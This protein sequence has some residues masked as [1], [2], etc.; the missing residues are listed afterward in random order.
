[1]D[2]IGDDRLQM[3]VKRI[4]MF[5]VS[6]RTMKAMTVKEETVTRIGKARWNPIWFVY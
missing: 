1:V 3:A 5:G 4:V 2:K 6:V